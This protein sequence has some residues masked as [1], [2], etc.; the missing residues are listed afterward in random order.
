MST[1]PI[2]LWLRIPNIFHIEKIIRF[3]LQHPFLNF[4]NYIKI[5]GVY[6]WSVICVGKC[7]SSHGL[8]LIKGR[9]AIAQVFVYSRMY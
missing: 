6:N 9:D 2:N 8:M 5:T 1:I 3:T 7:K 4:F